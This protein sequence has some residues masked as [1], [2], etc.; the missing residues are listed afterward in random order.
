ML[1]NVVQPQCVQDELKNEEQQSEPTDESALG[2]ED[3][4]L[5][6]MGRE[7]AE[8]SSEESNKSIVDSEDVGPGDDSR[9]NRIRSQTPQSQG[10][11]QETVYERFPFLFLTPQKVERIDDIN[12]M[13]VEPS[14]I[15]VGS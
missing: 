1:D 13:L 4:S 14:I 5:N 10:D 11:H 8:N 12:T 7:I 9:N 2:E 6:S 3:V 15:W